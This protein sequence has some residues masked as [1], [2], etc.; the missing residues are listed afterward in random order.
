MWVSDS[1]A[2]E[3]ED[4]INLIVELR[5]IR[6]GK[7]TVKFRVT[8]HDNYLDCEDIEIEIKG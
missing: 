7:S 5:G 3:G 2:V 4:K 6:P 8:T 1:Y